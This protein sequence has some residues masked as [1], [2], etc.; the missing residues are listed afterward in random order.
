MQGSNIVARGNSTFR[1]RDVTAAVKA[2]V[3]AG[4]EYNASAKLA[5]A[6]TVEALLEPLRM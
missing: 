1:Q 4:V 3:A 2:V 5:D 6:F